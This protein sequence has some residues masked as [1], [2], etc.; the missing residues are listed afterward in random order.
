MN[1]Y[2]VPVCLY[3]A[4]KRQNYLRILLLFGLQGYFLCFQV[5]RR[6]SQDEEDNVQVRRIFLG[7]GFE[8]FHNKAA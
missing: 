5:G 6:N 7:Q 1:T 4:K 3:Y 8:S 2:T